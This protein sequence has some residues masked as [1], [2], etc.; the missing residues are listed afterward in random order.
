MEYKNA[1]ILSLFWTTA[2]QIRQQLSCDSPF[3]SL[4]I[5]QLETLRCVTEKKQVLMKE[6]AKNFN[7]TPPSATAMIDH[8]VKLGLISRSQNAKD[9]RAVHLA[10][11][12]KGGK[13]FKKTTEEQQRRL[14]TLLG[15]LN[16]KE[17]NQ[18]LKILIKM[19]NQHE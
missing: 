2:R 5:A 12:S 1:D 4:T 19:S 13:V 3:A 9:R 10:L 8:L 7:I 16:S 11:T 17:K 15:R 14:K 6:V 18:L